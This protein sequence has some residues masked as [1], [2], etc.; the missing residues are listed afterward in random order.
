M[1]VALVH[2]LLATQLGLHTCKPMQ[3]RRRPETGT[4]SE[5]ISAWHKSRAATQP[6]LRSVPIL[7]LSSI[8]HPTRRVTLAQAVGCQRED[9]AETAS[10][11]DCVS[12]E[13]RRQLRAVGR[14]SWKVQ[15][16]DVRKR[17]RFLSRLHSASSVRRSAAS[18]T[19]RSVA[20]V[21]R[22]SPGIQPFLIFSDRDHRN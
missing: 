16:K 9:R 14:R 5:S 7:F 21:L 17:L 13:D 15:P 6:R 12:S 18:R 22:R 19:S 1:R 10:L 20:S 2:T 4:P 3:T 8:L 11:K